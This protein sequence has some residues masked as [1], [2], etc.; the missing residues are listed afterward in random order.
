[1]DSVGVI[2]LVIDVSK[3][4]YTYY[5]AIRDCDTDI[6]ELRTQLLLLHHTAGSLTAALSRD[7]LSTQDKSQVNLA[8]TKCEDAAKE[9][10]AALERIKIDGVPATT[11]LEKMKAVGK[12]AAYPFRKSTIEDLAEDVESCQGALQVAVAV[13]QLN[14]GATTVEQLAKLDEK[15]VA[16]TTALESALK[17]LALA[18]DTGKVEIVEHLL[19]N[20]K[21]ILQNRRMLEEEGNRR[22]AMAI[23][24]SL[25]YPQMNDRERQIHAADDSTLGD[26]F[27]GEEFKNHRQ[28]M[29]LLTFLEKGSGLFWIQGKPAS[30]KSTLMKYLLSRSSGADK[31]WTC[32]DTREVIFVS[33]FCWVAGSTSQRSLQG[34]LQSVLYQVLQ[35]DLTL[36]PAACPSQWSSGSSPTQ[37]HERE[38]WTCLFAAVQASDKQ[39]YFFIDGLDELQPE[40]NHV[41]LSK[42]LNRLSLH[43][44]VKL[45]VSSRPWAAF[46]R[47]LK[48]DDRIFTMQENNRLAIA[49]YVRSELDK[50][51]TDESFTHVSWDCIHEGSWRCGHNHGE[52]HDLADSISRRASGVFLWV[53]LVMEAVCRHIALGCPASV[54]NSYVD[55]L[56]TELGDYFQSMI[57]KRIHESMLSETAMA[58]SIA[59]TEGVTLSQYALLCKYTDTG[60]PWLVDPDFA[61]NMPCTTITPTE[62]TEIVRKTIN[63]LK[64]SCRDILN[65]RMPTPREPGREW[66]AFINDLP[67]VD[68]VHRTV[69]DYLHTPEMQLLL[70]KHSPDH[71][72]DVL[73]PRELDLAVCKTVVID[74]CDVVCP[75]AGW[76]ALRNSAILLTRID[77]S[78]GDVPESSRVYCTAYGNHNFRK[79]SE[80]LQ[81]LEGVGLYHLRAAK[82]HVSTAPTKWNSIIQFDCVR[83][84]IDLAMQGLFAFT[85]ALMDVAPQLLGSGEQTLNSIK[86]TLFQ[87]GCHDMTFDIGILRSLLRAGV[88]PNGWHRN[89]TPWRTFLARLTTTRETTY[90]V[91]QQGKE[92][93][94]CDG[95]CDADDVSEIGVIATK[96]EVFANS[97]LQDAIKTFV[98]FGAELR[99]EDVE[100]LTR[101]LPKPDG[102]NFNWPEFFT[103]YSQ[104]AKRIELDEERKKRLR[105]WP[106]GWL[107][108]E[109]QK[110]VHGAPE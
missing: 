70:A 78:E 17:D 90:V 41:V 77:P 45:V 39:F 95:G 80:S 68:F 33:H 65:C 59:L 97:Y 74:P 75:N 53:A 84:S 71:F 94:A 110:F 18:H 81:I 37:W 96:E 35:A 44:N 6:K 4:L 29:S 11:A 38:L 5:R 104:P 24:E 52:A 46:E 57:F 10:K 7:G 16:G 13:L 31:L 50:H 64:V 106:E 101:Y 47:N 67:P 103:A 100:M 63:F 32:S 25:K 93:V 61:S 34:L 1:M 79:P 108:E 72:K 9:L 54:L 26:L 86:K 87:L 85:D 98:E 109:D 30:G 69:F 42:A 58:L 2:S 3:D 105:R 28:T 21:I 23:V 89:S 76:A 12:K 62:L 99:N 15:L 48:H 83:L 43:G 60:V 14:I 91:L 51:A 66:S 56:P 102:N 49:R 107:T 19:Q 73:F 88:N 20:Q 22:K 92:L 36:V 40:R 82:G 55:K 8:F 27:I